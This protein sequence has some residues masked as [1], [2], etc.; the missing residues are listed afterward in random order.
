MNAVLVASNRGPVSFTLSEDGELTMRRGGGGLVSGLSGV[1]KQMD[2]LWVCAALS[3]DDRS[4]VRL[5]P[6][7]RLDQAGYDTGALRMLDIPPATFH[8]AY[9]AIANSTLWFINHLLY[10]TPNAPHFD[11]RFYREWESYQ[12]YNAAF[13]LALAEEAGPGARV[14]IQDYHLTLAPAMLRG[15]RPDVRIAHFSHTPWAPPEYFSLLPD[16]VGVEV[17]CG[18]L[19]ADHAGF[20][21]ER[22][23]MAFMDC[24]ESVLG[25]QVDRAGRTVTHEGRTTRIGVHPLGVDGEALWTRA[26]EPDVES[27]MAALRQQVGDSRLIVRIDRTELS[28]NIVRG[29]LAYREFLAAHPEWHGRVVHLAFAYPSRHDLPEYREYTAAVQRCA[30][31]IEDDYASEDWD[32]LILNVHD[33]Y[34]RSLAAYRLADVLLVNPIR[35]GMNLVAKEGPVLSPNAALVLSREAG[36]AAELGGDAL[37]VNPYDV[38]GTAEA[39]HEGLVMPEEERAQRGE[40]LRSAATA[41]PPDA[42]FSEQLDALDG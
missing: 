3:D 34:P 7:G 30:K 26:L 19:G 31:E 2:V 8:R 38:A 39:L 27:H 40:R 15:E 6:G 37:L 36:A 32:P 11:A 33:D 9:N 28:K 25:A 17:L 18:I 24:C 16:E 10:D 20:L 5:A 4:A 41:L 1:V 29:L 35:D 21:T 42:W 23:A 13:A 12:S 14:M 22:W